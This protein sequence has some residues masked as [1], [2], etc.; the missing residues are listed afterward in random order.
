[1]AHHEKRVVI[2]GAGAAGIAAGRHLVQAGVTNVTI[3]EASGRIGGRCW[4]MTEGSDAQY[5]LELGAGVL[6]VVGRLCMRKARQHRGQQ[7]SASAAHLIPL[8]C[9]VA[10]ICVAKSSSTETGPALTSW[11]RRQACIS[12][13]LCAWAIYGE[14]QAAFE[15]V[16]AAKG[17]A[18]LHQMLPGWAHAT[19]RALLGSRQG[20]LLLPPA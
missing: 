16:Y 18:E 6:A 17:H 12:R 2:I 5:P 1:M 4:T 7:P 8:L 19:T 14:P 3:F 13:R 20:C 10:L 11:S 15:P 9:A